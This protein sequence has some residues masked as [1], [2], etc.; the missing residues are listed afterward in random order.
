MYAQ[1]RVDS[2]RNRQL[3]SE[4][5]ILAIRQIA[6]ELRTALSHGNR[7]GQVGRQSLQI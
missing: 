1:T 7:L 4:F 2:R 3:L 6:V 5:E